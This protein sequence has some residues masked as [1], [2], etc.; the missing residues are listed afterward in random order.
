MH[1]AALFEAEAERGADRDVAA[2]ASKALTDIK[3]HL[4]MIKPIAKKYMKEDESESTREN[5][6]TTTTRPSK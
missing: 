3:E 1:A 5:S 2:L 4:R 6:G